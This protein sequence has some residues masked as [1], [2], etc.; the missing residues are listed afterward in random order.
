MIMDSTTTQ[1]REGNT[2][3]GLISGLREDVRD[4][5]HEEVLLAKKEVSEKVSYLSRNG[6]Y[7]GIGAFAAALG[8]IFLLL[9]LGFV[10][11][12]GLE[13]AGITT[14][15]ALF[16]GFLIVAVVTGI[17][18]GV[19]IAKALKAFKRE[20]LVPQKTIDT[21]KE[22]K[23]GGLEQAPVKRVTYAEPPEPRDHRTSDEIRSDLERT[24]G[25]IGREVRGIKTRLNVATA[26]AVAVDQVRQNPG[27]ALRLGLGAG[28]AG[29]I[30]LKVTRL[31]QRKRKS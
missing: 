18:G 11:A 10:I 27:R 4:L 28:I 13:A 22:I 25:R 21:L 9:A 16:L 29:L 23:Q 15:M 14:G 7:L 20:S 8:A 2:L 17:V 3:L 19:L 5:F 31:V 24:R 1:T 26:T 6:V 12:F 30:L